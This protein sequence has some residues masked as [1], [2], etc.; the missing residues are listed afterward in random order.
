MRGILGDSA[1]APRPGLLAE[2]GRLVADAALRASSFIIA[3]SVMCSLTYMLN[4]TVPAESE[5]H[6]LRECVTIGSHFCLSSLTPS[7]A[8][9]AAA[10]AGFSKEDEVTCVRGRPTICLPSRL[11]NSLLP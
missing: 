11:I 5:L 10:A 6:G 3:A 4:V 9:V 7:Y 8:L 1:R 2:L